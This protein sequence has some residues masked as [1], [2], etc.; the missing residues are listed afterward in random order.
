MLSRPFGSASCAGVLKLFPKIS[1]LVTRP[2]CNNVFISLNPKFHNARA[3]L[4]I[5]FFILSFPTPAVLLNPIPFPP[6]P[7]PND[8]PSDPPKS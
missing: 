2:S 7:I 6:S 5:R 8:S 3:F 4:G 1:D